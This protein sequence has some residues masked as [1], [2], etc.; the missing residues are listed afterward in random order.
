MVYKFF[1]KKNSGAAVKNEIIYNKELAGELRKPVNRK[2]GKKVHSFFIDNIW[3]A[4]L[5]NIQLIG[6]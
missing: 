4:Y 6:K 2:F 5:A 3:G 1:D